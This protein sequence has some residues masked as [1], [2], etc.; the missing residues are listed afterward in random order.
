MP[1]HNTQLIM[2]TIRITIIAAPAPSL[3]GAE[4][5]GLVT[6]ELYVGI[7]GYG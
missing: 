2:R 3:A 5:L 7:K 4:L 6:V 1:Q